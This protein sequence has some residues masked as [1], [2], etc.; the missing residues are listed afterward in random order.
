MNTKQS[1]VQC[2]RLSRSLVAKNNQMIRVQN[3]STSVARTSLY[4][5]PDYSKKYANYAKFQIPDGVPVHLK[6]GKRDLV[7]L[8]FT[9]LVCGYGLFEMF[10]TFYVMANPKKQKTEEAGH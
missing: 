2:A 8:Y 6:A 10:T 9:Y 1:L 4:D 3:L 5:P 7:L